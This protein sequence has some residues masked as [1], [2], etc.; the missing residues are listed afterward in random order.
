MEQPAR[1]MAEQ[2]A[3]AVRASEERRTGHAPKAVTVVLG[4]DSL[5]ITLR[6]VLSPA[7]LALT[8]TPGGSHQ[9]QEFHRQLFNASAETL[10]AEIER[11]TGVEVRDASSEIETATGTMVQVLPLAQRISAETWSESYFNTP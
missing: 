6:G 8:R 7:E 10:R 2:I 5:V 1:T 4:D 9:I 3:E 11:I